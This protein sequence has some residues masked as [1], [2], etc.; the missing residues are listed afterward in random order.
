MPIDSSHYL[1]SSLREKILEH[2]FIG[3]VLKHPWKK[4]IRDIE[5]LKAEVDSGGYDVVISCNGISR[6]I[7]LKASYNGASTS[8]QKVQLSL[9][10]KPSGCVIW[11]QF[12]P[13]NLD[14]GPFYWFG[15]PPGQPLPVI[16]D[17]KVAK[18]TKGN[19]Q[20]EKLERPNLRV[21]VKRDFTKLESVDE[22]VFQLFGI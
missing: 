7:Q 17:K 2:L 6:H 3:E 21:L 18:H 19:A 20:G 5:V 8:E 13:D 10:T 12:D 11:L 22:I 15:C 9:G 1:H 4:N 16:I 14:L